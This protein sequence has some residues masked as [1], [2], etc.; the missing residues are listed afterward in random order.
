MPTA[1]KRED[2]PDIQETI[3]GFPK[4]AIKKVGTRNVLLPIGIERQDGSVNY[5]T[6]KISLYCDLNDKTKGVNMSRFRITLEELILDKKLLLRDFIR[7]LMEK[8]KTRLGATESYAKV[9]FDYF[10]VKEAPVSKMKS[11][12][13][14]KCIV[15][16]CHKG[17]QEDKLFLTVTVPYTSLCPCSKEIAD[18]GAHNQPS[19]ADVKVQLINGEMCWIEE[20]VDLVES[21]A[22]APIRNILK[23]EDEAYQTELMY[24]NPVF[25]EDMVRL[26][27]VKLDEKLDKNIADYSCVVN[28][29]ESIHQNFAVSVISAGRQLE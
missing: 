14:M 8:T 9:Q 27:A 7:E 2:L 21:V 23:R 19:E 10:L 4:K 12:L 1:K 6:A 11:H 16:G 28:H 13:H 25:V 18:Y 26:I 29:Y 15:E 22:S 3:E 17:S 20:I 5:S 24:E